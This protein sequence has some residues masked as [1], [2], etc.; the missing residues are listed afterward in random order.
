MRYQNS[1]FDPKNL[2]VPSVFQGLFFSAHEL[3][4]DVA[5]D[6]RNL[7]TEKLTPKISEMRL[8]LFVIIFPVLGIGIV[9]Y[10][11]IKK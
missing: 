10:Q 1:A 5:P 9:G 3:K 11:M 6:W 7:R 8:F 4:R 2:V